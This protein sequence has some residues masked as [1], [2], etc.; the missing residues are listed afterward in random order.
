[1]FLQIVT[2]Y[3]PV[4]E[5]PPEPGASL[6]RLMHIRPQD[7]ERYVGGSPSRRLSL[8]MEQHLSQCAHCQSLFA[9]ALRIDGAPGA[10]R[11]RLVLLSRRKE[12]RI[13]VNEP[14]KMRRLNPFSANPLDVTIV[15]TSVSGFK[16][17]VPE[18]LLIGA[19]VQLRFKAQLI[20]GEVRYCIPWGEGYLAGIRTRD[21]F[22]TV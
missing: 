8:E 13:A 10:K 7:L 22:R 3:K 11:G 17:F 14:A 2:N 5:R 20:V 6:S 15:D 12:T 21:S 1:M 16:L 4:T 19:L 18:E 9:K